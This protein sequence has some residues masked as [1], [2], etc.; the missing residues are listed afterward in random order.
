MDVDGRASCHGKGRSSLSS[1]PRSGGVVAFLPV[2]FVFCVLAGLTVT[3]EAFARACPPRAGSVGRGHHATRHHATRHHH[4]KPTVR[5]H[6]RACASRAAHRRPRPQR[7]QPSRRPFS[8]TSFW[9]APLSAAAP[10]DPTRCRPTSRS[11]PSPWT[12]APPIPR[13]QPCARPL[14]RCRFRPEPARPRVPMKAWSSPSRAGIACGSSGGPPFRPMT[15]TRAGEAASSVSR[16]TRATTPITRNG[17][18]RRRAC[19]CSAA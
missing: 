1:H 9:N 14:P 10:L 11:S 17:V 13:R 16:A 2:V 6:A 19:P 7:P 4:G 3:D 18:P 8:P 15:G 5:R 12:R